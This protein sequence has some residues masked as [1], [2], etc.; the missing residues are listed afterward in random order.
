MK[1]KQRLIIAVSIFLLL[2]LTPKAVLANAGSP[3]MWFGLF[4]LAFGNALIGILESW[5]VKKVQ[6]LNIEAWKIVLGNYLSMFFGLY[7]IAPFLAVAAGNRDFWRAT[8]AVEEYKLGGFLVGMFFAYLATLFL[9]Y[10]FFKWAINPENKSKALP[11]T[12]LS[13]TVSYLS[14]TGIYFIINLPESKW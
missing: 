7:Y 10:P 3:M 5:V 11:A 4:H 2:T 6:K 8:R 12:L 1:N 9:E 13:N 14:M